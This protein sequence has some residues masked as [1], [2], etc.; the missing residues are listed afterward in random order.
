MHRYRTR[1]PLLSGTSVKDKKEEIKEYFVK[2]YELY[3][4]LFDMIKDEK[5]FYKKANPLRHPLIFYFGHTATFFINKLILA[6]IISKRVDP[7]FEAIFAVGVDEMSWDDLD[8]KSYEWPSVK[9]V[10]EYRGKVKNIIIDLID[11]LPMRLPIDWNSPFW[12]I[13]MGIEHEKIHIETSSVLIRELPIEDV[14]ESEVFPICL[15]S[16]K[17]PANQLLEVKGGTVRLGK[18]FEDDTYGWDNEYGEKIVDIKDFKASKYLVSNEE[19]FSFVKDGGYE[20]KEYWS[21]EGRAWLEYKKVKHPVFW[22]KAGEKY[23]YRTIAKI[24]DMPWD[25]PV[26]VNFLEAEAF[27]NYLSKKTNRHIRLPSEEEWYRLYDFTSVLDEPFWGDVAPANINLEHFASSC[28]VGRF[29]FGGFYDVIGNVWQWSLTPIHGFDGFKVHP[30]YDDFSTPTFDN[31]HNLIKGGSFISCGNETLRS[32]RYAFRRHFFQHAGFRYVE[33]ENE[34]KIE[35]E[36][37]EDD[38]ELTKYIEACYQTDGENYFLKLYEYIKDITQDGKKDRALEI[39]TV[40]GRVGFELTK[41][42]KSVQAVDFTARLIK[43]AVNFKQNRKLKY[44]LKDEGDIDIFKEIYLD[45]YDFNEDR[46]EFWQADMANLKPNF[47]GYD[48]IV[49]ND[50]I[51]RSYKPKKFLQEAH[52]RLNDNGYLVV[53]SSFD[54]SESITPKEEWIGGFKKNGENLYTSEAL[55]QMLDDRFELVDDSLVIPYT[56]RENSKKS[57]HKSICVMVWR[58]R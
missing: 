56:I 16:K 4:K 57:I 33:S 43:F 47:K 28:S 10:K 32:S 22:V 50:S 15:E 36:L 44:I 2:T 40:A 9:E 42:Y 54:W 41:E 45:D 7:T 37:Y 35:Q 48:L 52:E 14:V 21:E 1:V 51:D 58:K 24:I 34:V 39:G 20:T 13:L 12:A 3:E 5:T 27:C 29:E 8:E 19:F 25:W 23:R 38:L 6:K 17:A 53:S 18:S 26:D 11:T 31:R 30:L 55:K 46:V 49:L